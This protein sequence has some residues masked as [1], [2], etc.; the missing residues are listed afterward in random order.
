LKKIYNAIKTLFVTFFKSKNHPVV[1]GLVIFLIILFVINVAYYFVSSYSKSCLVCHYMKPYY[2][3]SLKSTHKDISCVTCH[4]SRRILIAP[5]LLRYIA[6]SYNPRPRAD[7]N[8]KV[9]LDCHEHQNLKKSTAFA[10]NISFNH[11]DHLEDLKRGKKLRCTSCHARGEEEHFKV[12]KNVCYTCHFKGAVR[13]H[14][15]TSCNVCHGS[16]KK[17]IEHGGFQFDHSSYLKIGVECAQCHIDVVKGDAEVEKKKCY[18]C[19]VERTEEFSNVDKIHTVHITKNGVD[20]EEC[21]NSIQHG[22]IK[23]ISS[24]EAN[25]EGCHQLKHSSQREMYIGGEGR[26]VTS[27][28]SRMFAAQVSCEGCH[29]DLNK[30]GKSDLSE[31]RESCVKCH[32]K[33]YGKMLDKWISSMDEAVKKIEPDLQTVRRFVMSAK[34]SG[35]NV[36][37]EVNYLTDAEFNLKLVKDGKGVHNIEYAIKLLANV[38]SNIEG[39]MERMG[40]KSFKVNRPK[41][42][43]DDAEYCNLCHSNIVSKNIEEFQGEKFPHQRHSKSLKCTSCHSKEEHKKITINK[44]GCNNCHTNISNMPENI[45]YGSILLPHSLHI[46]KKGIECS[47]CHATLDFTKI[48][49]KKN[50]CTNCHHKDTNLRK[51]C[52]K[53]HSL[54]NS[55]FSGLLNG[56]KHEPDI[57][58]S[59]GVNCEGCHVHSNNTVSKPKQ[60][61]CVDCHDASY[62]DMQSD[63]QKEISTKSSK[64]S[65]LITQTGKYTLTQDDKSNI[66][67]ASKLVKTIRSDKSKGMHNYSMFSSELDKSIKNLLTITQRNK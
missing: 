8:D 30:D 40:N 59:A 25:C 63:W 62:K 20:C 38:S 5:Y 26:G 23:M 32:D 21:H 3:Q 39:I 66:Q 34:N 54:Q 18:K 1:K 29:V 64:L 53:C 57:M 55:I 65:S 35:K 13:G 43:T 41:F 7:V 24:L 51:N 48:Q 46:R 50:A 47:V 58:K 27:S 22:K 11:S 19:H 36:D 6:G 9:C 60:F 12:D 52:E 17:I 67:T 61:F 4:P 44:E 56:N 37:G 28:P 2:E 15:V 14:S 45:K 31:R 16:P 49:I 33:D 10:M 42:L